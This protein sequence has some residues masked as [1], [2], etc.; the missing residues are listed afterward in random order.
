M[1]S[2]RFLRRFRAACIAVLAGMLLLGGGTAGAVTLNSVAREAILIDAETGAVLFEKDADLT[3]PPASMSKLMTA[4]MVF[5]R[6]ADGTLSMESTFPVSE[7]AWRKG[8][9]KMFVM[10]GKDIA[11]ADLLRGIIVQSG[12]DACIVIAEGIAGD[13]PTFAAMM[14]ERGREIG[15][16]NS[17]FKNATGWP[18]PEHMMSARDLATLSRFMIQTYPDY[19]RL[20]SEKQ[21][22]WQGI[23]QPNRNPLLSSFNGADGLKTGHTQEAGYG[24]VA[25]AEREGRRLISVVNG[26]ESDKQRAVESARLLNMGFREFDNYTL[27]E[28]GQ[29][30]GQADVW[31]GNVDRVP[32][33]VGKQIRVT[34]PRTVRKQLK[35]TLVYDMPIPA[36]IDEGAKI[37]T[38]TLS[39]PDMPSVEVP[40]FA[41]G[42]AGKL[43]FVGRIQAAF[44]YLLWG[45]SSG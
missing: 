4:L 33:V 35:A 12:N 22:T 1:S 39:A 21:F 7:Y 19:Y 10:V 18:D 45:A 43:S 41:G 17:I 2:F 11:V 36:P 5:D 29:E 13:E 9:S 15:L 38:L 27:L 26:L 37:G 31:L 32:L 40:L 42:P 28:A 25:S 14:T 20:F 23:E 16:T 34:L 8:G 3:M 24:L 44:N 30:V 6:L